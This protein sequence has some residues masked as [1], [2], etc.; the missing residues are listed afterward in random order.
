MF[1]KVKKLAR[2]SLL[3]NTLR[4]PPSLIFFV[5]S[6]CNAHCSHCF[7]WEN[8]NQKNDLTFDEIRKFSNQVGHLDSLL[9]SGGEPFLR[10]DLSQI[11]RLFFKNN[12]TET[13]SIPTNG[14]CPEVIREKTKAILLVADGRKVFVNISLDG[15]KEIHDKIRQVPGAFEKAIETYHYLAELKK[16]N[17]NLNVGIIATVSNENYENLFQLIDELK[18]SASGL[19]R[20]NLSFL[21]GLPKDRTYTLPPMNN[22]I[23]VNERINKLFT[24]E[25]SLI[26]RTLDETIFKLKLK[27]L[28]K[29]RQVLTCQAGKLMGVVDANGDVRLCEL[30][31]PIGNLREAS[32]EEIWQSKEA[33]AG[34][35]K[36]GTHQ[37]WCTHECFFLPTILA[38]AAYYPILLLRL[39]RNW[40]W[41]KN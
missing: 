7:N 38:N 4:T 29:K 26:D 40:L 36:I 10:T 14:L 1:E 28:R 6:R 25:R 35:K 24:N 21:R 5:T 8:L 3:K 23:R 11:C 31:E 39:V 13:I 32:F 30:L 19:D 2:Y 17:L 9:L 12:K 37:C 15:T 33:E 18:I 20:L 16:S 41:T 34:R 27:T 22:L